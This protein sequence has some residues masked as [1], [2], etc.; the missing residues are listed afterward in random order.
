MLIYL[1][2][3]V[4]NEC[5]EVELQNIISTLISKCAHGDHITAC[6]IKSGLGLQLTTI[7]II[8]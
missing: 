2:H 4:K 6:S 5:S 1:K 8:D 3:S 7:L